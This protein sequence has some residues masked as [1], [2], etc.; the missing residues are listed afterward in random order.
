MQALVDY[1]VG[2]TIALQTH[3]SWMT[4]FMLFF[5]NLGTEDFYFLILPLLYWSIDAN[6]GIRVGMILVTSIAINFTAK[7]LFA[8]PRP[9]WVSS[10]VQPLWPENSFGIPSGHAQY[11]ISVWGTIAAFQ[12]RWAKIALGVM[13]FLIGF[14]R[15]YLGS[16]SPHDVVIGWVIGGVLLWAF[17]KYW[18]PVVAWLSGKTVGQQIMLAFIVSLIFIVI[19]YSAAVYRSD[20][21]LPLSWI[22][23]AARAGTEELNP[24]NLANSIT[25][26]GTFFGLALGLMWINS[27]GG[28]KASGPIWMRALRFI[29]GLIGVLIFWM[30]LGE[31]FPRNDD[32][33]SYAL[34]FFRYTL[35]GWWISGGA[36]WIFARLNLIEV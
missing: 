9:Y 14:S 33:I 3:F 36:P 22:D 18:N 11:G 12:K 2:L 6:I 34:R 28:F 19:G 17:L 15:V 16:H 24:V 8:G 35:V 7:L 25:P 20:F 4:P 30:W 13:I 26:A 1:G 27:L 23:N 31:I 10:H 29:I 32:L 5:S 21:Q